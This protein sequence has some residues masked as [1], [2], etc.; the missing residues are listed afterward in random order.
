M[1][2][3]VTS[4]RHP[5]MFPSQNRSEVWVPEHCPAC[6]TQTQPNRGQGLTHS[7]CL[8]LQK[9]HRGRPNSAAPAELESSHRICAAASSSR[10]RWLSP[11]PATLV[12]EAHG[13][14]EG[15][16]R[17]T[18]SL[19]CKVFQPVSLGTTPTT[20]KRTSNSYFWFFGLG[21]WVN[22]SMIQASYQ[23]LLSN[24][25]QKKKEERKTAQVCYWYNILN[26]GK[27]FEPWEWMSEA[28]P[29][30]NFSI[31]TKN[32]LLMLQN[33]LRH[34]LPPGIQVWNHLLLVP[35]CQSI[36]PRT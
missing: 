18:F 8:G 22:H 34:F 14:I 9:G 15:L 5:S 11:P 30:L 33:I 24:S 32:T 7:A 4:C 13:V 23:V 16:G 20:N 2:K 10:A 29:I 25:N 1:C 21:L 35:G 19:K 27:T 36:H 31:L 26:S 3:C 12:E 17:T 28:Y 6:A